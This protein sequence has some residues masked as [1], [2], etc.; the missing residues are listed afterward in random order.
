MDMLADVRAFAGDSIAVGLSLR[1]LGEGFD[2]AQRLWNQMSAQAPGIVANSKLEVHA[3]VSGASIEFDTPQQAIVLR[4]PAIEV[5]F[6]VIGDPTSVYRRVTL[7]YTEI[8]YN[9]ECGFGSLN[10]L[11]LRALQATVPTES[12]A[13]ADPNPNL[14]AIHYAGKVAE[15]E[16]DERAALMLAFVRI[17]Q[18]IGQLVPFP[19]L[20]KAFV[21][22]RMPP[23]FKWTV[24]TNYLVVTSSSSPTSLIA[25]RRGC[26]NPSADDELS[27]VDP[28][29]P[30]PNGGNLEFPIQL[31][32]GG[33]APAPPSG[34]E[35]SR[36]VLLYLPTARIQEFA[37]ARISPPP[38]P[39]VGDNYLLFAWYHSGSVTL[40]TPII[41]YRPGEKYLVLDVPAKLDVTV[42][43]YV[44]L[45]C[46]PI[47]MTGKMFGSIKP[48]RIRLYPTYNPATGRLALYSA[49]DDV[50][51]TLWVVAAVWMLWPLSA[52]L[53]LLVSIIAN[54]VVK[55][56]VCD[57]LNALRVDL[58]NIK[59]LGVPMKLAGRVSSMEDAT[60]VLYAVE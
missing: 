44:I 51:V 60:G 39:D 48:C 15:Y 12:R 55:R 50:D 31:K 56:I 41:G 54:V 30:N 22:V 2:E 1:S 19:Q 40:E 27:V 10:Q 9:L 24:L 42:W 59:D 49:V 21:A 17:P 37:S 33:V 16:Y 46:I 32:P 14:V 25:T 6:H 29:S 45:V 28:P 52:I 23:P 7:R 11:Q 20:T 58:A 38:I 4:N 34:F 43:A 18:W 3:T 35:G 13:P 47:V 8:R 57:E 5:A 36:G 26:P 53:S